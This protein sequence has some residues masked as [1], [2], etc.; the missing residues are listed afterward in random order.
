MLLPSNVFLRSWYSS[1]TK[2]H[3]PIVFVAPHSRYAF[4]V[5][6]KEKAP[7]VPFVTMWFIGYVH[8]S[9]LLKEM[10]ALFNELNQQATLAATVDELPRRIKKL[11]P[12]TLNRADK[13]GLRN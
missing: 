3:P 8:G 9:S 6:E 4:K 1:V 13:K 10:R 5:Q 7:H 12:Y 2:N 11:L